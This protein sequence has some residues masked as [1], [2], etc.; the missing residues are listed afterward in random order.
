MTMLRI[1]GCGRCG[2]DLVH[3]VFEDEW[4]CLQCGR[5]AGTAIETRPVPVRFER[6]PGRRQSKPLG[7]TK[8]RNRRLREELVAYVTSH[9]GQVCYDIADALQVALPP[10]QGRLKTACHAGLLRHEGRGTTNDP[11]RWFAEVRE[12]ASA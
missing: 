1:R 10:M 11:Y 4:R 3:D 9:P 6:D 8:E 12:E 7:I 2:G 5:Q